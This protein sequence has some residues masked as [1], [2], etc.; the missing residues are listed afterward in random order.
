VAFIMVSSLLSGISSTCS[1]SINS[2]C[3]DMYQ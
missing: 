3:S 1:S 2:P